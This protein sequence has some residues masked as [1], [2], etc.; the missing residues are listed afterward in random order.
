MSAISRLKRGVSKSSG[1]PVAHG[2]T[3]TGSGGGPKGGFKPTR[4]TS[5]GFATHGTRSSSFPPSVV[6][7]THMNPGHSAGM[8]PTHAAGIVES[9]APTYKAPAKTRSRKY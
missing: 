1:N 4:G 8:H 5:E 2:A 7:G 9:M 6:H 3:G